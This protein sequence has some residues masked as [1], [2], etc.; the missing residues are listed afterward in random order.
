LEILQYHVPTLRK[1]G[2]VTERPELLLQAQDGTYIE[3]FEWVSEEA[4]NKAHELPS[5]MKDIWEKMMEIAD[6]PTLS[7]LKE[8]DTPF[9]SFK[10]V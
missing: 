8:S 4:K 5:V 9:P 1:K 10:V 2:L 6:F 7:D 3:I